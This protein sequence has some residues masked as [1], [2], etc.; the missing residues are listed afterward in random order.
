MKTLA[1]A[2]FFMAM[3]SAQPITIRAG[4]LLDG[5]GG[6]VRNTTLVIEGSRIVRIDPSIKDATYNLSSLTVMPGW[7]DTHTHIATHFDRATG[8]AETGKN[9]TPQQSML[10]AA[11]NAYATLMAGFTTIQ[12]PG[13]A[14]DK[15]LRDWIATGPLP[16]PRIL[17]SLGTILDGTPDEIRTKVRKFVADGA[18]VI[19]IFATK[20]IREGGGQTLSDAQLQAG[21][22]EARALG[23][24]ALIHAQGPE[25][26]RAAVLAGCT[27]IEHG[28][29]LT[30]EVLDLMLEHGTYFDPNFGLLLHNY[31]EN[32]QHYLGIGNFD[33]A[34]FAYME[35]GIPIGIDTFKRALAK[36]VKIVFGTDGG[37]GAHGRNFEEF[38]YRVRDGGQTPMAALVAAQYTAAESLRLQDQIGSI[39]GN[40]GGSHRHVRQP[41]GR[42]HECAQSGLRDERRPGIEECQIKDVRLLAHHMFRTARI[43]ASGLDQL[44]IGNQLQV[45]LDYPRRGVGFRVVNGDAEFHR[46]DSAPPE[47]LCNVQSLGLRTPFFGID[48]APVIESNRIHH[49]RVALPSA[50]RVALPGGLR[51]VRQGA[52]VSED[53]PKDIVGR[54]FV[55]HNQFA[56]HLNNFEGVRPVRLYARYAGRH[57]LRQRVVFMHR[58]LP[59]GSQSLRPGLVRHVVGF[60]IGRQ[61]HEVSIVGGQPNSGKVRLA[62]RGFRRRSREVGLPIWC[63]R[64]ARGGVVQPIARARPRPGQCRAPGAARSRSYAH[65]VYASAP[66]TS[67]LR[68]SQQNRLVP[69]CWCGDAWSALACDIK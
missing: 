34:G 22:G 19:K 52:A 3:L 7:I 44:R 63:S 54:G 31:I 21:C 57:A 15:D 36:N 61:I 45:D 35:K 40:A 16:G 69:Q 43:F 32:K 14:I 62:I 8:R 28:N 17:T 59:L 65:S 24:R 64:E 37:A 49:H 60:E 12:S 50:H 30:D 58:R 66:G 2:A 42:H 11:E 33:E 68:H 6:L 1:I 41:P 4:T 53:F 46:T 18:D 10:Y 29:R 23:K 39:A 51:G 25:G 20:S 67:S 9:E 13:L 27:T 55:E 48:P 26:A 56:R 5:K 47:T 38:I